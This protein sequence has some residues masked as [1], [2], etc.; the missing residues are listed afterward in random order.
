MRHHLVA[1]AIEVLLHLLVPDFR[2][3]FDECA[4][5]LHRG[6]GVQGFVTCRPG[7]NLAHT[8]HFVEAREIHQNREAGKQLQALGEATENGQCFGN[9]G[10]GF[11]T[12]FLHVVIF[13]LH[14]AVFH[15][16]FIFNFGHADR[17]QKMRISGNMNGF[18]I[19]KSGQHHLNFSRFEHLAVML[20][21]AIIHFDI[22]L[23]KE[24]ENLRQQIAFS[25][26]QLFMPVFDI[27]GQRYLFRQP[28][29]ALLGQPRIIG[30][31]ITKWFVDNTLFKKGHVFHFL[32]MGAMGT[33]N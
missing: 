5:Q 14:F 15:E 10:F 18:H 24:P 33:Q 6:I 21:I 17:I 9:I 32:S 7:H 25:S 2:V 8:F 13:I 26:G 27:F 16:G 20:H 19:R 28:V 30:P 3:F 1:G 12:P 22:G 31:R 23:N 4:E 29:N 11:D